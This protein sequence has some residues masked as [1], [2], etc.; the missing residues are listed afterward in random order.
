MAEIRVASMSEDMMIFRFICRYAKPIITT[1][2]EPAAPASVGVKSPVSRP[3]MTRM[4]VARMPIIP[5]REI[6]LSLQ[7]A[8]GVSEDRPGLI[9]HCMAICTMNMTVKRIPGRTPAMN[10]SAM[11]VCVMKP[12]TTKAALGG[13]KMPRLPPAADGSE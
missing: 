5:F 3:P 10:N 4:K 2:T 1:A 13:I 6:N 8:F 9:L 7:L 12:N 11:F